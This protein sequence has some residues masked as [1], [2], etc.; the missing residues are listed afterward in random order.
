[1]VRKRKRCLK[2]ALRQI[3]FTAWNC[4]VLN[5]LALANTIQAPKFIGQSSLI[6]AW[7]RTQIVRLIF[8]ALFPLLKLLLLHLGSKPDRQ[9]SAD[10]QE[11]LL[12]VL[13]RSYGTPSWPKTIILECSGRDFH[14]R[15]R[16]DLGSQAYLKDKPHVAVGREEPRSIS[17]LHPE[18]PTCGLWMEQFACLVRTL[19]HRHHSALI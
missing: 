19:W 3:R 12:S 2:T 10:T 8:N 7:A 4:N 11:R 16:K 6:L 17:I 14:R 15:P 9:H 1:M 5:L 13:A 18:D